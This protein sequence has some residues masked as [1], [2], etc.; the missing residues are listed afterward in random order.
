MEYT[1]EQQC[2]PDFICIQAY[3]HLTVDEDVDFLPLTLSQS[4]SPAIISKD[5]HFTRTLLQDL[6]KRLTQYGLQEMPVWIEEWNSTLWQRDISGDTCYKAAWLVKN[7]CENYDEAE[8]FG[9]WLLSDLLE[10]RTGYSRVFHGG[11]GLFTLNGIPKSSWYAMRFLRMLGDVCI[12]SGDGWMITKNGSGL[13]IIL[14]HYCHYSDLYQFRYQTFSDPYQAYSVFKEDGVLQYQIS[15]YDLPQGKYLLKQY[16]ITRDH[17]SAFDQWLAMGAIDYPGR[18]EISYLKAASFPA[19]H[20]KYIDIQESFQ[21]HESLA[22]HEVKLYLLEK[23][24]KLT[25]TL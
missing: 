2:A 14:S 18:Q 15:L 11:Y 1:I 25:V 22:E 7:L 19:F 5:E 20:E 16:S 12:A 8:S 6:K 24:V 17:G 23:R 3:P 21:I 4:S 9:Y 13:Q 10:E